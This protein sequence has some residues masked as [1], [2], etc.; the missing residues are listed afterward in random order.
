MKQ[1][2]L[3]LC[4]LITDQLEEEACTQTQKMFSHSNL[5]TL[6]PSNPN[7]NFL[8]LLEKEKE[9]VEEQKQKQEEQEEELRVLHMTFSCTEALLLPTRF[10]AMQISWK[11]LS[12]GLVLKRRILMEWRLGL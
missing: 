8:A 12:S 5:L 11:P 9:Q 2:Q 10:S 1:L 4:V 6:Q 7:P 3:L